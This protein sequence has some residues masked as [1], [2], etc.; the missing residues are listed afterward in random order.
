MTVVNEWAE[1][2]LSSVEPI[3]HDDKTPQKNS[4]QFYFI[5]FCREPGWG[6]ATTGGNPLKAFHLAWSV[7]EAISKH[8]FEKLKIFPVKTK[9][10]LWKSGRTFGWS[11]TL[12][13]LLLQ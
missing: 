13:T 6:D 2:W 1:P 10:K 3:K 5:S 9:K 8:Q 11:V 12:I 4:V 7:F